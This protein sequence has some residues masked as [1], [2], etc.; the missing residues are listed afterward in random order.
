MQFGTPDDLR[1]FVAAAHAL[2]LACVIDWVPNHMFHGSILRS[3]DTTANGDGPYFFGGSSLR[4]TPYG[5]RLDVGRAEV[6]VVI[7]SSF[8]NS[9]S[10]DAFV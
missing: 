10:D 5:P 4:S 2:G 8:I 3:F 1:Q 7:N 9:Y 6:I